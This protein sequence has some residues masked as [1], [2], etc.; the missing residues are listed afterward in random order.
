MVS[1]YITAAAIGVLFLTVSPGWAQE[2]D[3]TAQDLL[4]EGVSLFEEGDLDNAEQTLQRIDPMQL[5]PDQRVT[6]F[7]TLQ[8]IEQRQA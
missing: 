8:S 4:N 5:E 3:A 7:E 1:R 2:N 6:L